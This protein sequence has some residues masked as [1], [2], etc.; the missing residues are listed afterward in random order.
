MQPSQFRQ[1]HAKHGGTPRLRGELLDCW[2]SSFSAESPFMVGMKTAGLDCEKDPQSTQGR[3]KSSTQCLS[4]LTMLPE[5]REGRTQ[6]TSVHF[7]TNIAVLSSSTS[8]PRLATNEA[9]VALLL[10]PLRNPIVRSISGARG[11]TLAVFPS[12]RNTP[13]SSIAAHSA[14]T[15][16]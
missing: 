8:V 10:A 11:G 9:L 6:S 7:V 4:E 12:Q 1:D 14:H 5:F 2:R 13:K 16:K 15:S 3:T